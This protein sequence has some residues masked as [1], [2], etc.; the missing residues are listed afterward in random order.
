MSACYYLHKVGI[1]CP[2]CQQQLYQC[3]HC[4]YSSSTS[5]DWIKNHIKDLHT[6]KLSKE[7]EENGKNIRRCK[8]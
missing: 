2:Y 6:L 7:L 8:N 3:P 5:Q 4:Y 1:G